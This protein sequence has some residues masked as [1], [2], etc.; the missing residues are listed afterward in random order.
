MDGPLAWGKAEW[1]TLLDNPQGLVFKTEFNMTPKNAPVTHLLSLGNGSNCKSSPDK[2]EHIFMMFKPTEPQTQKNPVTTNVSF[3]LG[4]L[5]KKRTACPVLRSSA[6]WSPH[7]EAFRGLEISPL[8][9]PGLPWRACW[10]TRAHKG[11]RFALCLQTCQ[12]SIV[13]GCQGP[14][15]FGPA[16]AGSGSRF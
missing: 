5:I 11:G 1:Q 8:C 12:S 2:E 14:P 10:V 9:S 7:P 15:Y 3:N 6:V 16:G 4:T 13:K